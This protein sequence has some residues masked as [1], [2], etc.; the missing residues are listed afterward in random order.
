[1]SAAQVVEAVRYANLIVLAVLAVQALRSWRRRRGAA[2]AWMAAMYGTLAAVSLVGRLLPDNSDARAT[3]YVAKATIL[4]LSVFPYA[5][6]RFTAAF[7]RRSRPV[8]EWLAL[9]L[10]LTVAGW[11]LALP[12][13]P[14]AG[15][16][17]GWF[18]PYTWAFF[19]YWVALSLVSAWRLWRGGRAQPGVARNRMRVLGL[20]A[21]TL[22]AAVL[23]SGLT[24][25]ASIGP[26]AAAQV[27][28]LVS[29]LLFFLGF[30][31]TALL[32]SVWR[33]RELEAFHR[34]EA[35]L[36]GASTVDGV[37]E[38]ILPH[39]ARLM[40]GPSAFLA[41]RDR[42]VVAVYGMTVADATPAARRLNRSGRTLSH[43]I[44][45]VPM[46]SGWLAVQTSRYTP[47]FGRDE[48]SLLEA[49]G[50]SAELALGRAE[51]FEHE[52]ASRVVLRERERQLAQAQELARL[53][54]WS[55]DVETDRLTISDEFYSLF[56]LE[57]LPPEPGYELLLERV[58]PDDRERMAA[59]A[60]RVWATGEPFDV[61]CRIVLPS[62]EM[63]W[64][65]ARGQVALDDSDRP[66]CIR[67]T[68]QDI[69]DQKRAERE[70][71]ARA[72]QQAAVARLGQRALES[73]DVATLMQE[74]TG[75]VSQ[76]LDVEFAR[77][78]ELGPA[79]LLMRAGVGW[80]DG[81]VGTEVVPVGARS[82]AGFAVDTGQPVVMKDARTETRFEVDGLLLEHNVISGVSVTIPG[83][84]Q[85]FGALSADAS[86]LRAFSRQ[87]VDF[88]VAIANVL[89][90][91]VERHRAS[92]HLAQLALHDPLTG[93]PNRAL[94]MDRLAQALA[95]ARRQKSSLALFFLDLDRFKVVNDGLGHSAGD[96][97][98]IAVAGR[99]TAVMRPTDTVARFGGDEFLILSEDV[100]SSDH[101]ALVAERVADALAR[102]VT[103]AG[104]DVPVSASIGMVITSDEHD[105]PESLI[106]D[107]D[108]A[109]YRAKERGR[110][111]FE[112]FDTTM[113]DRVTTR[114]E[115]E[116][117]LRLALER[118]EL[119]VMYQPVFSLRDGTM[120]GVEALLRWDHPERGVLTPTEFLP[121]AEDTGLIVPMGM[122]SLSEACRQARA[123]HDDH[124]DLDGFTV[125]VNFSARQLMQ[126][127]LSEVVAD[128]VSRT[129]VDPTRLGIEITE[130]VLM[131]D[132]EAVGN[133]LRGLK[134][135]GVQLAI[136]D[137][138]TGFSSL[139]FLKRLPVGVLKVDRSFVAGL[140]HD[141][142]DSAIVR[143]VIGLAHSLGLRAVAEGVKTPE[144]LS[145]LRSWGC[146]A[147]QGYHVGVP[148]DAR[149]IDALL[150]RSRRAD[151][152]G[153][154]PEETVEADE[155][156]ALVP[157]A[158][159]A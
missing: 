143:A 30:A 56:A 114:L 124:G 11:T 153:T 142:G 158:P 81:A 111:R 118:D 26:W 14:A 126:P 27:A 157:T 53:G 108:V 127:D 79:G 18:R 43:A 123:W 9:A 15:H 156:A 94:V 12:R 107:A 45:A 146:D 137:F 24:P 6:F 119:R 113:R 16:E 97:L 87:D 7:R 22:T 147:A 116:A 133:G 102:P 132:L 125:W 48:L 2:A 112:L 145:T 38:V 44:V 139:S 50:H 31:P 106:R 95:R 49:L 32:R 90:T 82:H 104:R 84:D 41:D 154:P 63:R 103:V 19:L 36:I 130:S 52:R 152:P 62:G 93:L 117:G 77:V 92:D 86:S 91:A 78:L 128:I 54:S 75:L 47:F 5:L 159:P 76:V 80:R 73:G 59:A 109:M 25:A 122:W 40:G 155:D 51:L 134:Q 74:A 129:L 135:L 57:Y 60:L 66:R 8:E 131:E 34:A 141:P 35:G 69:T 3:Q 151:E 13:L 64:V 101:A 10:A 96:Q 46:Q 58:H 20:G 33:R 1:M 110:A 29:A 21:V 149:T 89:A 28:A 121:L 140:G 99:L 138:G 120:I 144:Q 136:D 88:L 150:R 61:D 148:S 55:W 37:A 42:S 105:D 39:A 72:R 70:L 68:V 23:M 65:H 71:Q 98:L 4:G 67:G 115:T 85:P 100:P 17:S 83:H